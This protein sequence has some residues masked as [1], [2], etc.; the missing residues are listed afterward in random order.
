MREVG[1][2]GFISSLLTV[3]DGSAAVAAAKSPA[4][5][6]GS[7][8]T[9]S[10]AQVVSAGSSVGIGLSASASSGAGCSTSAA[11]SLKSFPTVSNFVFNPLRRPFVL[12]S[13]ASVLR[14]VFA[15]VVS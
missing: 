3:S 2:T 5:A 6:T 8:G 15:C 1:S 11:S 9:G 4:A 12:C 14:C 10:V 7:A 13:V